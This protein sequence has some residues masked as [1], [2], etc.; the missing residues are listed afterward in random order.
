[1]GL[2]VKDILGRENIKYKGTKWRERSGLSPAPGHTYWHIGEYIYS[3]LF[4]P[5][6]MLDCP[7]T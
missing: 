7:R 5:L 6:K 2:K 3:H 4:L 1:M